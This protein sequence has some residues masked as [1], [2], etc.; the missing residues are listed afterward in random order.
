MPDVLI[1]TANNCQHSKRAKK[2]FRENEVDFVEKNVSQNED[3]LD[4]MVNKTGKALVPVIDLG[5]DL[6]IG[7]SEYVKE[8]LREKLSLGKKTVK[9]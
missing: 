3:F 7:F 8:D 6:L 4:E 9:H 1:Y 2:F 5:N